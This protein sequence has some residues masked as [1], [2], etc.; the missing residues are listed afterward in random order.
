MLNL[1]PL[2]EVPPI[3]VFGIFH[4][5]MSVKCHLLFQDSLESSVLW[6]F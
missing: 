2:C 4:T 5:S 1:C 6:K 3:E